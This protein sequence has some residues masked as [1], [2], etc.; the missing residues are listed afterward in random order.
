MIPITHAE[1]YQLVAT[2]VALGRVGSHAAI[3]AA[4]VLHRMSLSS[5]RQIMIPLPDMYGLALTGEGEKVLAGELESAMNDGEGTP[6]SMEVRPVN[7]RYVDALQA[8]HWIGVLRSDI[9]ESRLDDPSTSYDAYH[10]TVDPSLQEGK[11]WGEKTPVVYRLSEL[12]FDEV[13]SRVF[14]HLGS[15][16]LKPTISVRAAF[17]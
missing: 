8:L 5:T 13:R 6:L 16:E 3:L 14:F 12:S 7:V 17:L 11:H 10:F 2:S 9:V 4:H 15:V 1:A